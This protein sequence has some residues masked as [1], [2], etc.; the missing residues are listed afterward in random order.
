[1]FGGFNYAYLMYEI[2][3]PVKYTQSKKGTKTAVVT[4]A[5]DL[6]GMLYA[7]DPGILSRSLESLESTVSTVVSVAGEFGSMVSEPKTETM[8]MLPNGT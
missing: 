5:E 8:C 1:M 2:P 7:H 6:W 4:D 3:S